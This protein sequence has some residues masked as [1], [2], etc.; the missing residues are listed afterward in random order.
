MTALK[1]GTNSV[2][3]CV[4]FHVCN[5]SVP[6]RL[7]GPYNR[8]FQTYNFLMFGNSETRK[9]LKSTIPR[10]TISALRSAE[11]M[12]LWDRNMDLVINSCNI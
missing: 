12:D 5:V 4:K 1:I 10:P 7:G 3:W 6:C 2:K 9:L 11:I 8:E